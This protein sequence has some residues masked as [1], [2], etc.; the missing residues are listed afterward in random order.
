VPLRP[1]F[2]YQAEDLR[3]INKRKFGKFMQSKQINLGAYQVGSPTEF[4]SNTK[5]NTPEKVKTQV[6]KKIKP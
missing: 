1:K 5:L 4:Y 6:W 3:E 2:E